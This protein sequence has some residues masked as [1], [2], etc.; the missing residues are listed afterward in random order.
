MR[1]SKIPFLS[2]NFCNMVMP[3]RQVVLKG[4]DPIIVFPNV[5][6]FP[7]LTANLRVWLLNSHPPS[8]IVVILLSNF[9]FSFPRFFFFISVILIGVLFFAFSC[10]PIFSPFSIYFTRRCTVSL[11]RL[12][13][14]NRFHISWLF[15]SFWR[16]ASIITIKINCFS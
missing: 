11:W 13:V 5:S 1:T 3:N 7:F 12:A 10:V 8:V 15:P 6:L 9:Y 14:Y 4:K 16:P 2:L